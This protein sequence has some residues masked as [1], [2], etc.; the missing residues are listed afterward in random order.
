MFGRIGTEVTRR[1]P[2]APVYKGFGLSQL[3]QFLMLRVKIALKVFVSEAEEK[4]GIKICYYYQ[5]ELFMWLFL[6]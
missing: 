4:E 5:F 3:C 1:C 6:S 2:V